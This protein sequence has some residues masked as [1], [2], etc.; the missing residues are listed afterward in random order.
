MVLT[1][2]IFTLLRTKILFFIL[3]RFTHFLF[4][5]I[6]VLKSGEIIHITAYYPF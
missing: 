3:Y 1:K 2:I 6:P 5:T 4:P